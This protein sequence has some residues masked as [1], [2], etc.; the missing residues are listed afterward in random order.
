MLPLKPANSGRSSGAL[1]LEAS[2]SLLPIMV[3]GL[4]VE[5][6]ERSWEGLYSEM[7]AAKRGLGGGVEVGVEERAGFV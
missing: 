2:L 1:L 4:L 5:V 6:V 3:E 7:C